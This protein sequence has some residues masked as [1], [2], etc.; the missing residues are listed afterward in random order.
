MNFQNL[1]SQIVCLSQI[2][3]ETFLNK[4]ERVMAS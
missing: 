2:I 3:P 1:N 4:T